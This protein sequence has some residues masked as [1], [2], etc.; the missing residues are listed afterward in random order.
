MGK[1]MKKKK[2]AISTKEKLGTRNSEQVP[3]VKIIVPI[4]NNVNH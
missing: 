2:N 1:P 4:L 3:I